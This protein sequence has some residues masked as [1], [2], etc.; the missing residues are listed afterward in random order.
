M[1]TKDKISERIRMEIAKKR[2]QQ[3]DLMKRSGVS[4]PTMWK[5]TTGQGITLDSLLAILDGLD[6]EIEFKPKN[7]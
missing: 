4:S 3:K 5:A 2:I 1:D 6:L 7:N